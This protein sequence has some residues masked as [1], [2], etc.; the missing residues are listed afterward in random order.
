[1]ELIVH[2]SSLILGRGKSPLAGKSNGARSAGSKTIVSAMVFVIPAMREKGV[3]ID[4]S[5]EN[6][7][8]KKA[9]ARFLTTQVIPTVKDGVVHCECGEAMTVVNYVAFPSGD[10]WQ[11]WRCV[12]HAN[13]ITAAL[14]IP[15]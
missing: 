15:R 6:R 12:V 4:A 10:R 13:H 11:F 3:V 5:Y 7:V 1:M 14:P 8:A 2:T 9:S